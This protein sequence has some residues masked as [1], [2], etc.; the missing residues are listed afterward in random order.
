MATNTAVAKPGSIDREKLQ[1]IRVVAIKTVSREDRILRTV[2]RP[3]LPH[4]SFVKLR[5]VLFRLEILTIITAFHCLNF[6][7]SSL[8]ATGFVF[9][10][11]IL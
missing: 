3:Y 11:S 5:L 9:L 6:F 1:S 10:S 8:I 2:A 7:Q 4:P